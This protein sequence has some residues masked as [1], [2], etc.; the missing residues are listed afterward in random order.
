MR[1]RLLGPGSTVPSVRLGRVILRI[2][3][4]AAPPPSSTRSGNNAANADVNGF[5]SDRLDMGKVEALIG[6]AVLSENS[7]KLF[8]SM[9]RQQ[10]SGGPGGSPAGAASLQGLAGMLSMM[11]PP[12]PAVQAS[13]T[14]TP[15][16]PAEAAAS[17]SAGATVPPPAV[18]HPIG[19]PSG[20]LAV[21]EIA[22]Q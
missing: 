8:D 3:P 12:V 16:V 17:L 4:S 2:D 22:K 10:D 14:P 11:R 13:P 6:D 5:P 9:K 20:V 21:S 15:T 1:L 18:Q 19:V 7:R